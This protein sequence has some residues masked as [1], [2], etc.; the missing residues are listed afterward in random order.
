MV[1]V[2][3]TSATI[4][5]LAIAVLGATSAT[6][7]AFADDT[8]SVLSG[9]TENKGIKVDTNSKAVQ[10]A[11]DRAKKLGIDVPTTNKTIV[12]TN[13]KAEEQA[14][15]ISSDNTK[16][17]KTLTDALDTYEA[18]LKTYNDAVEAGGTGTITSDEVAQNLH[19]EKSTSADV[20]L[21]NVTSKSTGDSDVHA[22]SDLT[23]LHPNIS[24]AL[25][26]NAL[27]SPKGAYIELGRDQSEAGTVATATY[28]NL[29]G[30]KYKGSDGVTH[31]IAK[32]VRTVSGLNSVANSQS[33]AGVLIPND[34]TESVW[35][36]NTGS[37]DVEDHLY[38]ENGNEITLE[39]GR[40]YI[41]PASLNADYID[42]DHKI[43]LT[44]APDKVE[45][46]KAVTNG[47]PLALAGSSVSAHDNGWLFADK[48]N[49]PNDPAVTTWPADKGTWDQAG[50]E[51]EYYGAGVIRVA[52]N[53]YKVHFETRF[54][55]GWLSAHG[56]IGVWAELNTN[57]P[58]TK[59]QK[60]EAPKLTAEMTDLLVTPSLVKDV[61]AGDTDGS[62]SNASIDGKEVKKGDDITYVLNTSDLPANR[63]DDLSKLVLSDNLPNEVT[64]KDA[65]AYS[66]DGKDDSTK[67]DLTND[68][69]KFTGTAKSDYLVNANADKSTAFKN[70]RIV[71]HA[72]VNADN[73]NIKNTASVN[74]NGDDYGSNTVTNTTPAITPAKDL[75]NTGTSVNKG[76]I[77]SVVGVLVVL[78]G[79][80]G[81]YFYKRQGNK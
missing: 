43:A 17:A 51:Y 25:Q 56:D 12:T 69:Q 38:D 46:V 15:S 10:D 4:A 64:F 48:T 68:G 74:I 27:K 75:P 62:N 37:I 72:T 3:R 24:A 39:K 35:Y 20:Q 6:V 41:T 79:G 60:P 63:T 81:F 29:N 34:P 54:S 44:G 61:Q 71:I 21:T 58:E 33:P 47:T 59:I 50:G 31:Q 78:L 40:A 14:K 57:I 49:E 8:A 1:K 32:I 18:D 65:K 76:L 66:S 16:Q 28:T 36:F 73:A 11:V 30:S 9:S 5:T 77:A 55:D 22:M 52:G 23:A 70:D 13:D 53:G 67:W 42:N 19:Y 7:S 80:A 2:I 26:G 45:Q